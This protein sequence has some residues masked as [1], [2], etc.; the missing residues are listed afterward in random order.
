MMTARDELS[1]WMMT[2]KDGLILRVRS[3]RSHAPK[4][5]GIKVAQL[6]A[7]TIM[8]HRTKSPGFRARIFG[9]ILF[10]NVDIFIA[11][12][13][14][15]VKKTHSDRT[16]I[17]HQPAQPHY[18][19]SSPLRLSPRPAPICIN[20][21]PRLLTTLPPSPILLE[22]LYRS[23]SAWPFVPEPSRSHVYGTWLMLVMGAIW[24][25]VSTL[26][27]RLTPMTDE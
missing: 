11:T 3:P 25:P 20:G 12:N 24:P 1:S 14:M 22:V 26:Q 18:F 19:Y 27:S 6:H 15:T 5:C 13:E 21:P 4:C 9:R 8:S 10:R 23:S 16:L 17:R 7:G 2:A